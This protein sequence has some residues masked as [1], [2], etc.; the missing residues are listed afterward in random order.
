[1]AQKTSSEQVTEPTSITSVPK[2]VKVVKKKKW[3]TSEVKA[4]EK[5]L[6]RF[7]KTC[8]VPGKKKHC[9]ACIKAEPVALKGRVGC[10]SSL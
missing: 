7:I 9:E 2:G 5:H 1:Q 4:V 6:Y 3:E 10:L 8:T